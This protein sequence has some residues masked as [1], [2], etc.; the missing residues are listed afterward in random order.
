MS[1][2]ED[3]IRRARAEQPPELRNRFCRICGPFMLSSC[4]AAPKHVLRPSKEPMPVKKSTA[5]ARKPVSLDSSTRDISA[6]LRDAI[7]A[8]DAAALEK[9]PEEEF[10]DFACRLVLQLQKRGL[11]IVSLPTREEQI[12]IAQD[13]AASRILTILTNW[14]RANPGCSFDSRISASGKFQIVLKTNPGVQLFFGE[15][16]QDAYAQAAQTI[17]FNS[18][19]L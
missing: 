1:L 11:T 14:M 4:P 5:P 7:A 2:L 9:D 10:I 18:G 13:K 16:I 15:S 8:T 3:D 12:Q 19:E 6:S 17:N